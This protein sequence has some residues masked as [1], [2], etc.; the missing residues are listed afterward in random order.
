ML[1]GY[2]RISTGEQNVDLQRDALELA[3]KPP[4]S[5]MHDSEIV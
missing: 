2:M 3:L 1:I 4:A 5:M